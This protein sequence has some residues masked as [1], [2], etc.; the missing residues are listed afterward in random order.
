LWDSKVKKKKETIST[1]ERRAYSTKCR[2]HHQP[3]PFSKGGKQLKQELLKV[4]GKRTS[5]QDGALNP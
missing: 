5:T 3:R 1:K 2:N 4:L